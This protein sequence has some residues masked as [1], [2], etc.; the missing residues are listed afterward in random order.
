MR[1]T[2]QISDL[3]AD[4]GIW[5]IKISS[6]TLKETF[7]IPP[8]SFHTISLFSRRNGKVGYFSLIFPFISLH[9]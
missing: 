2:S 5:Y 7:E 1:N 6:E 8:S 9:L 3:I 4:F